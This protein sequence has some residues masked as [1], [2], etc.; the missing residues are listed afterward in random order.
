MIAFMPM[1]KIKFYIVY[2][3]LLVLLILSSPDLYSQEFINIRKITL[4]KGDTTIVAGILADV[5][6][7]NVNPSVYYYWYSNS[8]IFSNQG[9][10][11][12]NL[13]HGEYIEYS[14]DGKLILKGKYNKGLK[15]GKWT[16]WHKDG[17]IKE[18]IEYE[19]GLLNGQHILYTDNGKILMQAS[20]KNDI[21]NGES[22]IVENDTLFQVIYKNGIEKKRTPLHA[23]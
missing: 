3:I 21:L 6:L 20:Y 7:E 19:E 13:L 14:S 23:F 1:Q 11:S 12:G 8:D 10:Y 15:S 4:T 16:L 17:S 22:R 18:I 9:G 2:Q 5:K